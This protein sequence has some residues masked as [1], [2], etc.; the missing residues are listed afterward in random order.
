MTEKIKCV[1]CAREIKLNNY[2]NK[3]AYTCAKCRGK[4]IP[5]KQKDKR[6]I[7]NKI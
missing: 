4:E 5:P 1:I 6:N 2:F 3:Q 7:S